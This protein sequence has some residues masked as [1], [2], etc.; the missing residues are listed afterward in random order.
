MKIKGQ[1]RTKLKENVR[2]HALILLHQI[3]Y[4]G[5]YSNVLLDR[6]IRQN[7]LDERDH[8]FLVQVVYGTVQRRITLDYWLE[9]FIQGKKM[10][11]WVQSLLRM[12]LYQMVYLDRVPQHAIL[13]EAVK[14]GKL[15][16]HQ[17]IGNFINGILRAVSRQGLRDL[18]DPQNECWDYLSVKA[19]LPVWLV[20]SLNEWMGQPDF[21]VLETALVSLLQIPKLSVR[22]KGSKADRARIK[23][24]IQEEGIQVIESHVSP[25]GLI[26]EKGSILTS[27]AYRQGEITVQDESSML[28]A[29]LGIQTG[30][31][32]VLDACS[33]PGGK[34]THMAS[35]L[36]SGSLLA[37][38]LSAAKLKKVEGHLTRMGL[39]E[40][41]SVQVADASK[42]LP[43]EG[44][45]YDTIYLDA[46]CSGLGLMRRKPEI[47]YQ[48]TREDIESLVHIQGDLLE[49]VSRFLK[50]GGRLIYSTCTLSPL[51]NENIIETFLKNHSEFCLEPIRPEEVEMRDLVTD[52]GMIRVWPHQAMS[53]GFF[54]GRLRKRMNI[55]EINEVKV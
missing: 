46:P 41:A 20:E 51:E 48:K 17:G 3:E 49:H 19:S 15:N 29:P 32:K 18:P 38:D 33:A 34:A 4:E 55:P 28:V 42:F 52:Q 40:K 39:M 12:S 14:I 11:T 54:I 13:N 27:S 36:D 5:Q 37:L 26:V 45:L 1:A 47:K 25:Y 53:D 16:G 9:P 24:Q 21:D 44:E 10:E 35:L 8:H 50:P 31:E 23:A 43:P 6:F 2:W 22:I 30:D 7:S